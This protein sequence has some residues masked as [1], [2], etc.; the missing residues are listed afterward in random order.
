M[1]TPFTTLKMAVFAPMPSASVINAIVV[2]TGAR[3]KSRKA[4]RNGV[5]VSDTTKRGHGFAKI[6]GQAWRPPLP[7]QWQ[8]HLPAVSG[9]HHLLPR[10]GALLVG[11]GAAED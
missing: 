4:C 1:R 8:I 9:G 3:P 5:M 7:L 11:G 2:N 10:H 6:G